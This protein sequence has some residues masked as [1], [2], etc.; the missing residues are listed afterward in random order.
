LFRFRFF[1]LT[2]VFVLL[3]AALFIGA[4][5]AKA[6]STSASNLANDADFVNVNAMNV[7]QIQALLQLNGSFLK[8]YS[9][10]KRSAAQIIY[11]AAHGHGDA[12]ASVCGI[13]IHN[14]I[15][16]VAILAVLQKEQSLITM[17]TKNQ[18]ALNVAMGYACPDSGGCDSKYKGFTKQ[19]ENGAWQLRFNFER[20]QGHGFSDYQVGQTVK[21]DGKKVKIA[22]HATAALYR[23]TPHNSST[24]STYFTKWN[25][26]AALAKAAAKAQAKAI[27]LAKAKAKAAT[28]AKAAAA[29]AATKTAAKAK[30]KAAALAK[31]QAKAAA[32]AK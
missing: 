18:A 10:N 32:K 1:L 30:A 25:S 11:D 15:S 24:F 28:K 5:P 14:T 13:D 31:A 3:S 22:N 27:A 16:P 17:K 26:K 2:F 23:Y 7:G 29:K 9:E 4:Q 8:D 12:S 21:I 20:A 6:A 19:V